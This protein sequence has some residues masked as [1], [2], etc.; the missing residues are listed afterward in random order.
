MKNTI[1]LL[2]LLQF[3]LGI[4]YGQDYRSDVCTPKGTTVIA[5]ITSENSNYWRNYYDTYY[6]NAYPNA[7][8][9]ETYDGYSSTR[10]FNCH[11]YAWHISDGGS[12]RWI[13]Y[14]YPYDNDPEYTYWQDGSYVEVAQS[15]YPGKVNWSSGDHSA[16]TTENP[17][18]LISKWN[19]YPLMRHAWDDSPYGTSNLKYYKL[20]FSIIGSSVLCSSGSYSLSNTPGGSITWDQSGG[21]TRSSSQGSNPCTFSK[22]YDG[23]AYINASFTSG[24]GTSFTLPRKAVWVGVPSPYELDIT[25]S[26][27]GEDNLV[28]GQNN[29]LYVTTIDPDMEEFMGVDD[30]DWYYGSGFEHFELEDY[31]KVSIVYVPSCNGSELVYVKPHNTCGYYG[32]WHFEYF[33]CSSYYYLFFTPNPTTGETSISIEQAN[34]EETALKS[35]STENNLDET[36]EWDLEV[37]DNVQNL[38]LK[39]DRLKGNSTKIQTASWKEGVYMVRVKYK[40][41]VLTGK[42]VVKK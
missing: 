30:Y 38:K 23:E 39:K 42:L 2:I 9:I 1:N 24:C 28:S 27:T 18:V 33:Y 6:A 11:G 37:Y 19:E 5:Y 35:A 29:V 15:V 20:N 8:Q 40:D 3:I 41:E 7:V 22:N 31:D 34:S 12:D 16:I 25:N 17:G 10:R 4:A 21:L 32:Y 26:N 13:G 14:G 36:A